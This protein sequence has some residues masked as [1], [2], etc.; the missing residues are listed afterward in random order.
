MAPTTSLERWWQQ[1]DDAQLVA[2]PVEQVVP[3]QSP[4]CSPPAQAC[5]PRGPRRIALAKRSPTSPPAHP[6]A[7]TRLATRSPESWVAGFGMRAGRSTCSEASAAASRQRRRIARL[8][9]P[10]LQTRTPRWPAEVA[11]NFITPRTAQARLQIAERN[12]ASQQETL[13]LTDWRHAQAGLA[14]SVDVEQA[15]TNM[16]QTG[17]PRSRPQT[18]IESAPFGCSGRAPLCRRRSRRATCRT[19]STAGWSGSPPMLRQRTDVRAAERTLAPKSQIS[20]AKR[21]LSSCSQRYAGAGV[22]GPGDAL[23]MAPRWYAASAPPSA[24]CSSTAAG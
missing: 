1:F 6:A 2:L 14:S 8:P 17:R 9:Q 23:A 24:A 4:I 19:M 12:L 13:Q 3:G 22:R 18:G 11:L 20:V 15:R 16:E 5:V 21:P 10:R 7:Q